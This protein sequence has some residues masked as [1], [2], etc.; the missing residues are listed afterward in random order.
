MPLSI[1]RSAI[2]LGLTAV[3][4]PSTVSADELPRLTTLSNPDITFTV[5]ETGYAVLERA[6]VRAVIVDNRAVDD[7][8][9]PGHRAGYSGV[10]SLTHAARDKNLFVPSYAGLN[11]EHIHD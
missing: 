2:L 1:S 3:L 8:T 11:Y 5:P 7:D 9:L 4:T 10:A 6:G